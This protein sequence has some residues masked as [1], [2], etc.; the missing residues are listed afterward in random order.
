M[1]AE[2]RTLLNVLS[3]ARRDD[4]WDCGADDMVRSS[5]A[6]MSMPPSN[7]SS[8]IASPSSSIASSYS[9]ARALA[10][11]R[12][13]PIGLADSLPEFSSISSSSTETS[14]SPSSAPRALDSVCAVALF[15]FPSS[16][17]L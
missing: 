11:A 10:D 9:A 4:S 3:Y 12:R 2:E 15:S 1:S 16:R 14:L 7:T 13:A 6:S 17:F 5:L 8:S